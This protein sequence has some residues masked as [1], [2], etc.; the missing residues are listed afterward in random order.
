M[1]SWST[2]RK[3]IYFGIVSAI[4]LVV[5]AVPLFFF[6]Y[7][8]PT[9]S[10]G[11][12]NGDEAGVD[13]G[14]SCSILCNFEAIDPIVVWN[15]AFKVVPGI[16]SAVAYIENPNINSEANVGYEFKLYDEKNVLIAT[17]A[18]TAF[19]PKNKVFAIFEPNISTGTQIP[20]RVDFQFTQKPVWSRSIPES[21]DVL[22]TSK[23]LSDQDTKPR[24][25]ARIENRSSS[26][27][28]YIE[29]LAIVYDDKE[30]AIGASRTFVDNLSSGQ[31]QN[32]TFTW[33]VPFETKEEICRVG[34]SSGANGVINNGDVV[35]GQ[36]EALGVILAIDRSG[37]MESDGKNPPEPLTAV[38][39]AAISFIDRLGGTDRVGVISFATTASEPLD[40]DLTYDYSAA[41]KAVENISILPE[42]TQYT[43]IGDAIAKAFENLNSPDF[44]DISEKVIVLLTDGIATKPEKAGDANYPLAY[45]EQKADEVRK[46][47]LQVYVI[48]LGQGVN[49][50]FLKRISSAPDQYFSASSSVELK[51][52]YKEIAVEICK[53]QPA[54]IEIIPRV[55]P[56][57]SL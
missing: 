52:I 7:Q 17:R 2:R 29:V 4:F 1:I 48:G 24:I 46:A 13:C 34:G 14:G 6:L 45:A 50:E 21:S 33:P 3:A 32:V 36:A 40:I 5:I 41:K 53:S 35:V 10:D 39:N 22:V 27:Q 23:V 28:S 19:I 15:R 16:Y 31:S 44:A 42:G 26:P 8:E 56:A 9:C 47:G 37:S 11:H 54:V 57:N 55:I 25:E 20:R 49:A 12:K 30:N 51:N 43:N 18:N 38:K